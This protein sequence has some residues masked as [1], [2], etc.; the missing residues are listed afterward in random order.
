M[1]RI[2][3]FSPSFFII[4]ALYLLAV[5]LKI[6][7]IDYRSDD[8]NGYV[9]YWMSYIREHGMAHAYGTRFSNYAPLYTYLLGIFSLLSPYLS[10]LYIVKTV[11]FAGEAVAVY[12]V[13]EMV[14]LHQR[15]T[16]G[17]TDIS[18]PPGIAAVSVILLPTVL[19]NGAWF[20]QCDIWYTVCLLAFVFYLSCG[21][22]YKA[23]IAYGLSFS[24]KPQA[25]FLTPL[26]LFCLLERK[27]RW[28]EIAIIPGVYILT[29]VPAWL[30]GRPFMELLFNY[31]PQL[32]N[33]NMHQQAW[34]ASFM[35]ANIFIYLPD[36]SRGWVAYGGLFLAACA[37]GS[38]AWVSHRRRHDENSLLAM[39]LLATLF[40]ALMPYL[41][42]RQLGRYFFAADIFSFL[43]AALRPRWFFIAAMFQYASLAATLYNVSLP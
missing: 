14:A 17:S 41:L 26:L 30:E 43:L 29:C 15:Q 28:W 42:P 22:K 33:W 6:Y 10:T 19:A 4:L 34:T 1:P 3:T 23:L 32:F 8:Y 13:Y 37:G 20:G 27:I 5:C 7:L 9:I 35:A 31:W 36:I 12:Y 2:K 18:L 16:Q 38:I 40:A 39:I 24:F 25:I 21:G 11:T